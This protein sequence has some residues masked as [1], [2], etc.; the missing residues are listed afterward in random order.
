MIRLQEDL[1]WQCYRLY[2]L[3]RDD[4]VDPHGLTRDLSVQLGERAFEIVLA[5]KIRDEE[6]ATTWFTRHGSKPITELPA[7]WS[8]DY[9]E[10]VQRRIAAI[11]SNPNIA[12]IE[13]PEYKRR[14]TPGCST[15]WSPTSTSTAV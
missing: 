12:L 14:C 8:A 15:D 6:L 2:D 7:H 11:E 9:R 3:T 5:R 4:L 1:D 13:Q 10:L